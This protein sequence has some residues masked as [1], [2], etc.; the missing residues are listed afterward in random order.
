M[1]IR[2]NHIGGTL[3]FYSRVIYRRPA[4]P[5][6]RLPRTRLVVPWAAPWGVPSPSLGDSARVCSPQAKGT[7]GFSKAERAQRLLSLPSLLLQ[8]STGLALPWPFPWASSFRLPAVP[9][10][11]ASPRLLRGPP[12]LLGEVARQ[13]HHHTQALPSASPDPPAV[14]SVLVTSCPAPAFLVTMPLSAPRAV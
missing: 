8:R 3:I 13:L 4:D 14:A 7:L 5:E 6:P 1:S 10:S 9:A 11:T 12:L 2:P